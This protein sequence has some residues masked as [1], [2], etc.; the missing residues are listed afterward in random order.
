L[1]PPQQ[2]RGRTSRP[3]ILAPFLLSVC[4]PASLSQHLRNY[5]DHERAENSATR[6]QVNDRVSDRAEHGNHMNEAVHCCLPESTF[7]VKS[8]GNPLTPRSSNRCANSVK[9][10]K[11]RSGDSFAP[12]DAPRDMMTARRSG[13]ARKT[14]RLGQRTAARAHN[15]KYRT[16]TG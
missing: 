10:K 6:E 12:I 9:Q 3:P 14:S 1:A 16:H 7:S 11:P 2:E 8:R 5:E 13:L 4:G 15:A